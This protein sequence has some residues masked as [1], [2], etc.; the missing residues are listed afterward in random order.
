MPSL[1]VDTH[2]LIW[3]T[4]ADPRLSEPAREALVEAARSGEAIY[5]PPICLIECI[6]LVE[7]GRVPREGLEAM[8]SALGNPR[9][10][11]EA[12]SL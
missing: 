11:F 3:Y 6:Y 1:V 2:S 4:T 5:I 12:G 9:S 8:M 7:K 10:A